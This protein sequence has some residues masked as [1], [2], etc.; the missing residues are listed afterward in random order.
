MVEY[1]VDYIEGVDKKLGWIS[2]E[3]GEA[4]PK[5]ADE[6]DMSFS[7]RGIATGELEMAGGSSQ[8]TRTLAG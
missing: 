3:D 8:Q 4:R 1:V 5:P 7:Q 2:G 6:I